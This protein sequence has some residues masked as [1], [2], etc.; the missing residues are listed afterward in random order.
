MVPTINLTS[1]LQIIAP[2]AT[3]ISVILRFKI[4]T[5]DKV[6]EVLIIIVNDC[7]IKVKAQI[8]LLV[9]I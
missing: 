4:F 6:V 7:L 5:P 3:K 1:K 8:L 9:I 2:I